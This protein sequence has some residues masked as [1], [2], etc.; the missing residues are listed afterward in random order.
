M[1]KRTNMADEEKLI[2]FSVD[3]EY[4]YEVSNGKLFLLDGFTDEKVE[5]GEINS[6][7]MSLNYNIEKDGFTPREV[8]EHISLK[9]GEEYYSNLQKFATNI[10][11]TNI[12]YLNDLFAKTENA[13]ILCAENKGARGVQEI[14]KFIS[15]KFIN[16]KEKFLQ[17]FWYWGF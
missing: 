6:R 2:G 4:D 17:L 7:K 15:K 8:V 13:K 5:I 9:W 1:S 3:K 14:N 10:D 11:Y 12:D 16:F